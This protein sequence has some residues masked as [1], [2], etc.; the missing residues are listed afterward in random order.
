MF[1]FLNS[2]VLYNIIY[3]F[4]LLFQTIP[5][6]K[7][8]KSRFSIFLFFFYAFFPRFVS[9]GHLG[10]VVLIRTN[11]RGGTT[12]YPCV[13]SDRDWIHDRRSVGVKI[14]SIDI[15]RLNIPNFPIIRT[16]ECVCVLCSSSSVPN[17]P[18][19]IFVQFNFICTQPHT[20]YRC[21]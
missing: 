13:I 15:R 1:W 21:P 8:T 11:S 17:F 7:S 2:F 5:K 6:S 18:H 12:V 16:F 19:V 9:H 14:Y 20:S 4:F 10:N 3:I